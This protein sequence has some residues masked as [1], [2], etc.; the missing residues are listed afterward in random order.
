[1]TTSNYSRFGSSNPVTPAD[2][3]PVEQCVG[4]T[5]FTK[6]GIPGSNMQEDL[7]PRFMA[8]RCAADFDNYCEAYLYE[9]VYDQGGFKHINK[10]FLA[11][12]ARKKYCRMNSAA[13]GAHCATKCE[14]FNPEGQTSVQICETVGAQNWLDTKEEFDLGGNFPQSARLNPISPLYLGYCPEICDA[15]NLPS[16][17]ALG[18]NDKVLNK[19]IEHGACSEILMDLAYNVVKNSIPVTNPAFQSIINY[20]KLDKPINPNVIAKIAS[21]YGLPPQVALDVLDAAKHGGVSNGINPNKSVNLSIPSMN[22]ANDLIGNMAAMYPTKKSQTII[23]GGML[24]RT[25]EISKEGFYSSRQSISSG[26][27]TAIAFAIVLALFL[28]LWFIF[29]KIRA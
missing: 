14:A 27:K 13:P 8:Q 26:K 6:T 25:L 20:A 1:M 11:E 18:P 2:I 7:C 9:S 12:T 29:E 15:A 4:N 3:D 10:Q 5:F 21:S 16:A 23:P 17:D 22:G 19:C 28:I 24:P